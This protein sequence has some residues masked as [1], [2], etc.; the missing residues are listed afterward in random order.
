VNPDFDLVPEGTVRLGLVAPTL[1]GETSPL[2]REVKTE[3]IL[4]LA[5]Q[6]VTP[7]LLTRSKGF[8]PVRYP[9]ALDLWKK[10]EQVHW[11]PEEVPLADDV[12]DWERNLTHAQRNF[13]TQVFRLFVKS[14]EEVANNYMDNL[15]QYFKPTEIRMML[16]GFSAREAVH[17][18]AY[19]QVLET[20]GMPDTEYEAFADYEAMSA[21]V[22]HWHTFNMRTDA[23]VLRTLAMFGGFAEGLQVF[24]SFAMLM[25]FPRQKQMKSMGQIVSWSVRDESMH[26]DGIINLYHEYARETGALTKAVR[27]DV[28]DICATTIKLEDNFIDLAFEL[29]GIEDLTP[30][31][32]KR[33]IR[34]IANWRLHQLDL[35]E[36]FQGVGIGT[37]NPLPWLQ[38]LL[39][40]VEHANFFEARPTAYSKGGSQGSYKDV[41]QRF[42][43]R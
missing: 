1:I 20:V 18:E 14:D 17:I 36:M 4:A 34:F 39:S 30:E 41:W 13:L 37:P 9:W 3:A 26:C 7:G 35:P 28:Q 19:S 5:E 29:G 10:H 31:D 43:N 24:A 27:D 2:L 11:L 12:L 23:D 22:A 42:D 38:S 16:S 15:S 40:G 8:K 32:V 25:N 6:I 21:K 33:Y